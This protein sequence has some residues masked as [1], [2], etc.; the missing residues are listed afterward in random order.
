MFL[1][2]ACTQLVGKKDVIFTI[3]ENTVNLLV[4]E[5]YTPKFN[6]KNLDTY[7]FEYVYDESLI[8][9][10]DDTIIALKK[11][12]CEVEVSIKDRNDLKPVKINIIIEDIKVDNV[13]PESIECEDEVRLYVNETYKLNIKINPDN[14]NSKIKS[15]SYDSKIATCN[16]D[17]IIIGKAVG[18]TY[19]VIKSA[20]NFNVS[21]RVLVIVEQPP[22]DKIE[23][24]DSITL[25]YFQTFQLYWNVVPEASEQGV[26][27]TSLNPDVASVDSEG[28]ITTNKYG[29]A[30]IR[31]QSVFDS[32]IYKDTIVSVSGDMT[33]DVVIPNNNIQLQIG[34]SINLEYNVLPSTA[35][36][37]LDIYVDDPT[38]LQI[39]DD[40]VTAI[41]AGTYKLTLKTI[42]STN[43]IKEITVNVIGDEEP[44][45]VTNE[46]FEEQSTLS[47]NEEFNPFD[48]IK[49]FDNKDGDI[50]SQIVIN[51]EV[52]NLRYGE[53]ML[54]YIIKDTDGNQQTLIRKVSVTWGYDV[55]VIGHAGSY[56]GVPN[57][58]EAILYAAEVLKY[59]A[60][61]ID[62]KQTKDG[63]FVLSHDPKWGDTVLDQTNYSDLKD[64]EHTVVKTGGLV[65]GQLTEEERTY[66]SKICTFER[67]LEICNQYNIIA[68]I[69]LKTSTGVSNWTELNAPHQSKMP[70]IMELIK[71]YDML[72]RVIF[73]SSQEQCLNWVKTHGYSH[74]PCQYLTLSSCENE[75]TYNIVKQY[76]L[77]I[78]FNV[79]D[80]IKISDA[81]LE[82]YRALGCK[83]AVFTFEEYSSYEDIQEWIDRGVD[84]VTTDWHELDKL[85]LPKA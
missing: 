6:L 44:I 5:K 23:S 63:V 21:K 30:I 33:T 69:E 36:P 77:D 10:K 20:F 32:S 49:A 42:D 52:D 18:Q 74:I 58:E 43:I 78:S 11:G 64:V 85:K 8:D 28:L 19:I 80:G 45:F 40:M 41:K 67:Y 47:W 22:V 35:Y 3:E 65:G 73:L 27:I 84:Y 50:T 4:G 71:K 62:L 38:G 25:N 1:I 24:L 39:E 13:K 72:D 75:N 2:N 31:I 16:D 15:L 81:W 56:Y 7:E 29:T 26:T 82:K 57:S 9:I 59:P 53:Y 68:V 79:R 12:E 46:N 66:T 76:N 60:I 83:L 55:T 54:E 48:N 37:K 70:Q 51:G 61:E 14:A 17:G 34:T